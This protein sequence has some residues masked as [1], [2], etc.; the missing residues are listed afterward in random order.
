MRRALGVG[1]AFALAAPTVPM[2]SAGADPSAPQVNPIHLQREDA[3]RVREQ[4]R[5]LDHELPAPAAAAP[6]PVP[7]AV[8]DVSGGPNTHAIGVVLLGVAGASALGALPVVLAP[9]LPE[10][11]SIHTL[12]VALLVTAAITGITGIA[13]IASHRSSRSTVQLAPTATPTSVGLALVGRL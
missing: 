5:D 1:L 2:R 10:D 12:E 8:P 4:Q 9:D 7:A 11:S 3:Q 6:A 13:L